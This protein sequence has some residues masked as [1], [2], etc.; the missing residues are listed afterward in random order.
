MDKGIVIVKVDGLEEEYELEIPLNVTVKEICSA[1]N[2][3]LE[4]EEKGISISG[5]YIR[6][7]NPTCFLKGNDILKKYNISFGSKIILI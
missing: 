5:Y 2:K 4:L 6:T 7:E 1:L 3:A